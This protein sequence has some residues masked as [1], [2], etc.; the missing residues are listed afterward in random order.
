MSVSVKAKIFFNKTPLNNDYIFFGISISSE[1]NANDSKKMTHCITTITNINKYFI[2]GTANWHDWR[3]C[4]LNCSGY[5]VYNNMF[6]Q[7]CSSF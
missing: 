3:S 6:Y 1:V 7:L 5:N 2:A 4:I